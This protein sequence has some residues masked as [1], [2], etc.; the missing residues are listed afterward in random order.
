MV[1]QGINTTQVGFQIPPNV[2]FNINLAGMSTFQ[3][4]LPKNVSVKNN[5]SGFMTV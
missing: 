5:P 2:Q 1:Q 4:N 3:S